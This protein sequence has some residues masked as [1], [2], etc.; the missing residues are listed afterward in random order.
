MNYN[1]SRSFNIP[2]HVEIMDYEKTKENNESILIFKISDEERKYIIKAEDF[3]TCECGQLNL[4]FG[5]IKSNNSMNVYCLHCNKKYPKGLKLLKNKNSRDNKHS[6]F[7][8]FQ[9]DRN[10][11]FCEICH[12]KSFLQIHHI[13]EVKDGGSNDAENLQ[14]LCSDCHMLTHS[15]RN[16]KAGL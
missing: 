14:L 9:I 7:S 12:K 8:D 4:K 10:R 11:Y 2:S 5:Y 13:I 3:S 15:V 1:Y 16:I 6:Y